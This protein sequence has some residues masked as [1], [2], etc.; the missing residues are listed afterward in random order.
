MLDHFE[1]FTV[2]MSKI[3]YQIKKIKSEEMEKLN[4]KGTH[5]SCLYYLFKNKALTASEL[6]DISNEDKAAISRSVDYLEKEQYLV[7]E[8]KTEKRYKS[9]IH[10]TQKGEAIAKS[11][12]EKI[13]GIVEKAS[14]GL[15]DTDREIMYRALNLINGNLNKLNDEAHL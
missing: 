7:C 11:I 9:L 4:L 3:S 1:M 8:S 5:L 2:L 6:C 14:T 10:L 15:S 12:C 13:D